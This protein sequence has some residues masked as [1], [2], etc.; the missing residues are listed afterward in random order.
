[1]E[2]IMR[3][4]QTAVVGIA[5]ACAAPGG[6]AQHRAATPQAVVDELLG[7]DRSFSAASAKTDVIT[8]LSAMFADGVIMPTPAGGFAEGKAQAVEALRANP[9]N[10]KSRA[11]WMPVRGGV[12]ADGQHGFTFGYMGIERP[13]QQRMALKYLSYWVKGPDGWRVAAYKRGRAAADQEISGSAMPSSLPARLVPPSTDAAAVERFRESLAET[14]RT[15]S[16]DAQTIGIGPAFAKYGS[17]DA[18]N[19]GGPNEAGFV[20]GADAIGKAVSGGDASPTSSVSWGPDNVIVASSGDLGVSIG[21]IRQNKVVPDRPAAFPF[22]T[23][24]RRATITDP[25]RYIAE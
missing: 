18:V 4:V 13:D 23:I 17:A 25:W 21:M 1:M 5:I 24:W 7:T 14:E 10:A 9:D 6:L 2:Q 3:R 19:M 8:G 12:S 15:F 22:F 16:R 11:R 20:V